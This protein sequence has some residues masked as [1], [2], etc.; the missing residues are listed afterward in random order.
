MK[1]MMIMSNERTPHLQELIRY[2]TKAT[3]L[4]PNVVLNENFDVNNSFKKLRDALAYL[5]NDSDLF[6][7]EKQ[8]EHDLVEITIQIREDWYV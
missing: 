7:I 3:L 2:S 8:L 5:R 1:E 4:L 6:I